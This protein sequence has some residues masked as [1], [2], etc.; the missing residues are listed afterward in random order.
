[1]KAGWPADDGA[2]DDE[3]DA[4]WLWTIGKALVGDWVVP[5]TNYRRDILDDLRGGE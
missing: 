1:M 3:A 2:G 4:W 5:E